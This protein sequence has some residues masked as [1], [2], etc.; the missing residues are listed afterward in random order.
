MEKYMDELKSVDANVLLY[1][2]D[3]NDMRKQHIARKIVNDN[4]VVTAQA[5]AEYL[6]GME[7]K[8]KKSHPKGTPLD[9]EDKATIL[10]TCASNLDE[11][12]IQHVSTYTLV[13]AEDLVEQHGF[14]LRDA[15]IVAASIEAGCTTLYSEDMDDELKVDKQLTIKNPFKI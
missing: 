9:K 5:V 7:K 13:H 10:R 8:F 6:G 11:S 2:H 3:Y 4:P 12:H 14:Q 15:V 1:L